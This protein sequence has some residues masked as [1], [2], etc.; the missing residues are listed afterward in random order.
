MDLSNLELTPDQRDALLAHPDAPVYISDE[1]TRKVF[2]IIEKG[3][4]PELEDEYIRDGLDL[5]R[6][7]I[8]RGE[9][10]TKTIDEVI[11]VAERRLNS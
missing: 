2:M 3:Q 10:S 9:T 1:Q 11:A 8:A 6:G 5:A 7:Q 4:F